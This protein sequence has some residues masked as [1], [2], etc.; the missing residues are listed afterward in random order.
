MKRSNRKKK[1]QVKKINPTKLSASKLHLPAGATKFPDSKAI[2]VSQEVVIK[3]EAKSCFNLLTK[4]L[5]E[6]IQWDPM[7]TNVEPISDSKCRPGSIS[8]LTL[9]LASRQLKS[10]AVITSYKTNHELSWVLAEHPKVKES[11]F[12]MSTIGGTVIKAILG[13]EIKGWFLNRL[14]QKLVWKKKLEEI[15][16]QKLSKL[17]MVAEVTT[18]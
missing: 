15:L 3:A 10:P 9:N 8:R 11:W 13:Y 12:L 1:K 6:N 2:F 5:E 17:K 14:V 18:S 4:R 7:I 16:Q